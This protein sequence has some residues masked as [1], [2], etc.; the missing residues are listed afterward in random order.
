M[1]EAALFLGLNHS[2]AKTILRIFRLEKRVEKKN[3]D[4]ERELKDYLVQFVDKKR[5]DDRCSSQ[6]SNPEDFIVKYNEDLVNPNE[7]KNKIET[8]RKNS[9]ANTNFT[10]AFSP[11]RET[12]Q[13]IALP[14][15]NIDEQVQYMTSLLNVYKTELTNIYEQTKTNNDLLFD[16]SQI[17]NKLNSNAKHGSQ[18]SIFDPVATSNKMPYYIPSDY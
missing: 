11:F 6:S 3:A 10:D 17:L 8:E 2:T 14:Q 5:G 9:S 1:K 16:L 15:L 7:V 13:C 18:M 12:K 4:Y